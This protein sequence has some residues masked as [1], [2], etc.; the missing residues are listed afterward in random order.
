MKFLTK[1]DVQRFCADLGRLDL[2]EAI[3]QAEDKN[4]V[5]EG[6]FVPHGVPT[7]VVPYVPTPDLQELFIRKRKKLVGQLKDFRNVQNS[8]ELWRHHRPSPMH[9]SFESE[10]IMTLTCSPYIERAFERA[11]AM[12]DNKLWTEHMLDF[13]AAGHSLEDAMKLA[14]KKIE[15]SENE[16]AAT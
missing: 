16:E 12:E 11:K 15:R 2:I 4:F 8:K 1:I 9:R 5:P 3:E 14:W 13:V 10:G 6:F 7:N